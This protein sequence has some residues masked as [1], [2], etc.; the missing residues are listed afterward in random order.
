V[1]SPEDIAA[2]LETYEVVIGL[3]VHVQ[4]ATASKLFCRCP[5]AFGEPAN[6]LVCPVCTGQPGTL[7]VL[8]QESLRLGV[9]TGLCLGCSIDPVTHFDRK[10]Y[11]YPD[12]PKGYQISQ[13]DQP[14][15][16]DGMLSVSLDD[17]ADFSV[18]I[19]RAHLEEDSGKI[20]RREGDADALVDLNRAGVALIEIVSGPDMRSPKQAQAYLKTL[21]R[22]LRHAAVSD[23]DM[24]KGQFRCDVNV[25]LRRHG[26]ETLG[27]RTETK[28]LNSFAFVGAA[29]N[30]EIVR[31]AAML[32]AGLLVLQETMAFDPVTG[33]TAPMRSKE[34]SDDYR[35]FPEPDLP[36][37]A[38]DPAWVEQLR[39]DLPESPVARKQR[40]L[41]ELGL[42]PRHAEDLIA[43]RHLADYFDAALAAYDRPTETA[44]WLFT[45]VL[46]LSHEV[47]C[48]P[49]ELKLTG[50]RLAQLVQL[51]CEGQLS[52]QAGRQV[53]S[54]MEQRPDDTARQV[55]EQLDLLQLSGD[56]EL[57]ILVDTVLS[58]ETEL[59]ERFRAHNPAVLNALLG[60]VMAASHGKAN[61]GAARRLLEQRLQ[62]PTQFG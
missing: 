38:I 18:S 62:P 16:R 12:L 45:E 28:N 13:F 21:Q 46:R 53:I 34:D 20:V 60:A 11:F 14:L 22:V 3:E 26:S 10:N 8:N 25:S 31:Q 33:R 17:G 19:V 51:V 43:D 42:P 29:C 50:A 37:F 41:V 5:V 32:E 2:I 23:C 59:V 15:N 52:V 39:S 49:A 35:Y 54:A 30:S 27:T 4:L 36:S 24:E 55:A 6:T 61:P 7:P 48:P 9:L 58:T 1:I 44:N 57:S 47:G 56:A 40:Y